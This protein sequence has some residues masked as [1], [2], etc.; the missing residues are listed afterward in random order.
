MTK[1]FYPKW[2][3]REVGYYNYFDYLRGASPGGAAAAAPAPAVEG[4]SSSSSSL[5]SM[6][7]SSP[8]A[9]VSIALV[10]AFLSGFFLAAR[11]SKNALRHPS[12][13]GA[14]TP[15]SILY[16]QPGN[17][18]DVAMT[19]LRGTWPRARHSYGAVPTSMSQHSTA[20]A[21]SL[22]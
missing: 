3:L 15:T 4:A 8:L 18:G 9:A 13:S 2:W 17:A 5:E 11:L 7:W 19:P 6:G 21:T 10:V 20:T 16:R 14:A 1:L 12:P 22:A